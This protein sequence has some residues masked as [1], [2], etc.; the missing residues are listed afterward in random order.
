M[1]FFPS[2]WHGHDPGKP[3]FNRKAVNWWRVASNGMLLCGGVV[4]VFSPLP[5]LSDS[6]ATWTQVIWSVFLVVGCLVAIAGLIVNEHRTQI[7]GLTLMGTAM[8]AYAIVVFVFGRSS[9]AYWVGFLAL[10]AYLGFWARAA[11]LKRAVRASR[12]AREQI[13]RARA[14]VRREGEVSGE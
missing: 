6:V 14:E 7:I 4:T 9:S 12:G 3:G 10:H 8:I 11:E 5:S 13:E 1:A 2:P